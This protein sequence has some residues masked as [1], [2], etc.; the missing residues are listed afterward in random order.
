MRVQQKTQQQGFTLIEL[1][2]VVAIVAILAAVG[3]PAYQK[4]T[5]RAQFSEV[6]AAT[7]PAKTAV[8]ICYQTSGSVTN[9]AT[10]ATTAVSGAYNTAI[11]ND[12]SVTLSGNVATIQATGESE[13]DDA[14]Y[15]LAGTM[16]NGRVEWTRAASGTCVTL[17]YC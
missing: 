11:V 17:G 5:Q 16:A 1:M 3:M 8:E 6:I 2:I 9:C 14:T 15:I 12:V 7:G 4:Y 13:L 10:Q